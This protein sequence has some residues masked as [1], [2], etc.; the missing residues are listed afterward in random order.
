MAAVAVAV[1]RRLERRR[2]GGGA[3]WNPRAVL[4]PGL[5]VT[6]IDITTRGALIESSGRLR[7]GAHTELQLTGVGARASIPGRLDRCFVAALEPLRY[8]GVVLFD[9]QVDLG[10]DQNDVGV[11]GAHESS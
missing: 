10:E 5:P 11:A 9:R 8:R 4:R 7:P 6:L 2:A 1:E 3:K